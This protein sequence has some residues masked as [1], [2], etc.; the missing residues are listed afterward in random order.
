MTEKI[1]N[2]LWPEGGFRRDEMVVISPMMSRHLSWFY[3]RFRNEGTP[4][5]TIGSMPHIG[6]GT[7]MYRPGFYGVDPGTLGVEGVVAFDI[8]SEHFSKFD[9]FY[10]KAMKK[11]VWEEIPVAPSI[12]GTAFEMGRRWGGKSMSNFEICIQ[13][14]FRV[15]AVNDPTLRRELFEDWRKMYS[16]EFHGTMPGSISLKNFINKLRKADQ[17]KNPFGHPRPMSAIDTEVIRSAPSGR[18]DRYNAHIDPDTT[19]M[20][21]FDS[22]AYLG[23]PEEE[24]PKESKITAVHPFIGNILKR[25]GK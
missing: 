6:H 15:N 21:V 12:F 23:E 8:E 11:P 3:E 17:D 20:I 25:V 1:L 4:L 13:L 5:G 24:K 10:A 14:L 16:P 2:K 19:W 18:A 9:S 7:G 22:Y